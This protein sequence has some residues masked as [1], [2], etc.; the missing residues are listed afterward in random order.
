AR[1]EFNVPEFTGQLRVMAVSY[2]GRNYGSGEQGVFVRTPLL[3]QSSWPRFA[4]P[5]DRFS[6]P[7]TVFNNTDSAG[8][9]EITVELLQDAGGAE[10]PL[11]F[12]DAQ[13]RQLKLPP[14]SIAARGQATVNVDIT[15]A[16]AVGVARA[17]VTARLGG[18]SFEENTELPVRPP[19]PTMT[20]GGYAVATP[21]APAKIV[22]PA[23]MLSGTKR[24]EV[25]A[26][27]WPQ[28]DL[29][30]GLDYL[31]RYPH[32]CV[33]QITSGLFPLVYLHDIG[34]RIAPGLFDKQ[35]VADKVQFGLMR[36]IAMQ[37]GDGGLAMWPAYR[38]TWPWA[39]VYAAHFVVEAQA[40][41]YKVPEDFR[42]HL[43][44]YVRGMLNRGGDD[45]DL[46]E[47]QGYACYVLARAGR[48]ERACMD[49]LSEVVKASS[50]RDGAAQARFWLSAAWLE[51][52][53]RDRATGLIPD[54]IPQPRRERQSGG[55]VGSPIRDRAVV[56]LALLSAQPDHPALPA[57]VQQLAD[58]GRK[59]Q[60]GSTQDTAFAV[61]ALG[62]YLRQSKAAQPFETAELWMGNQRLANSKNGRSLVWTPKA[63]PADGA[64]LEL[65]VSGPA[66]AKAHVGWSQTGVALAPPAAADNGLKVRRRYLDEQ[67][68][69]L[70]SLSV[71]SG[72]LV[73]VELSI[74]GSAG[75][76]NVVIE[77][78][79]PAGLEIENP[80]LQTTARKEAAE[81]REKSE[82][83]PFVDEREEVRDDRLVLLGRITSAVTGRFVYLARAV[84]PGAFAVPPVRAECM[85]DLGTSSLSG[86]GETLKV[87]TA[88]PKRIAK[89]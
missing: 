29:P 13:E 2:A 83:P 16:Q 36:L 39:S 1:A 46:I 75:S 19:S 4:A 21:D 89:R 72:Q 79:L 32:G 35:R 62:R 57:L 22:V 11:T 18:E 59:R 56:I 47:A 64:T 73:Q 70:P 74:E 8:N 63:M 85:Y 12:A 27:P 9:V 41:G 52:G 88:E 51:S 87:T 82:E 68:K 30:E 10:N 25:R 48:P 44:A 76:K 42:D 15:A 61:M 53:R 33:E 17:R 7:L 81:R 45:S 26:T 77:D 24:L 65:R 6:V 50:A 5:G 28:L 3:V 31:D 14:V 80:R 37:T 67:G 38:E 60:W 43:L 40:A 69:P 20:L 78:L 58:A 55:N 23:G 71:R 49:R 66:G 34:E 84:T 54:T 86:G